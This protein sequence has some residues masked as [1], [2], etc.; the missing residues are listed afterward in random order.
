MDAASNTGINDI[1]EIIDSVKYGPVE[2]GK[3]DF[4]Q[5]IFTQPVIFDTIQIGVAR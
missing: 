5:N 2:V 3:W 4:G 1:R